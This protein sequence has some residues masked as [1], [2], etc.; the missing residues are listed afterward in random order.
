MRIRYACVPCS[1]GW[2]LLAATERGICSLK[3]GDKAAELEEQLRREFTR[4]DLERDEAALRDLLAPILAYLDG[5]AALPALPLDLAGTPF[6][7]RVWQALQD[8]P[9]GETRTYGQVAAAI[10]RRGAARAVARACA[11]N[12]VALLIPCHR[13]VR[14]DGALGG[15]RWGVQRKA[16]LLRRETK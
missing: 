16:A 10:G 7:R 15:Y 5:H 4:A 6:Q 9:W 12:P 1:L 13:V 11:A 14:Q 2:L 3:L 8:I